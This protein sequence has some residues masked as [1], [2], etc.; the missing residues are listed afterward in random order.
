MNVNQ[1]TKEDIKQHV[2]IH[3]DTFFQMCL[4]L[5]YFRAHGNKPASTYETATTRRFYRGRTE[6][7]R[8]CS[9]EVVKWCRAV[10]NPNHQLTVKFFLVSVFVSSC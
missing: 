2:H 6:T 4:Q 1:C 3:P 8:T 9:P 10:T 5:A 7:L